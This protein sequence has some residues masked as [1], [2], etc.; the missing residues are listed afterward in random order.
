M[1]VTLT[2]EK[3]DFATLREFGKALERQVGK[4]YAGTDSFCL[5]FDYPK[6]LAALLRP[7]QGA[8][9]KAKEMFAKLEVGPVTFELDSSKEE[10]KL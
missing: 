2:F 7:S 4:S 9:D 8:S 1:K 5:Y 10:N 6:E 3:K